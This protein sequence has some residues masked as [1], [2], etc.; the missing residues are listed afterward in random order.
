LTA[1]WNLLPPAALAAPVATPGDNAGL[2]TVTPPSL[3]NG[4]QV[5]S[6]KI[7]ATDASGTPISP[8]KSCIVNAP[9]TNCVITGLTNGETYK[10]IATAT[11]AAGS[12]T[13]SPSNSIVPASRPGVP[14]AVT[15]TRGDEIATVAFTPPAD[16]GG[17][18][19]TT[20]TLTVV[21]TGQTFTGTGSP[22]TVTG[23]TNGSSY[24]FKVSATNAVGVSDSSTAS[25]PV[26]IAGVADAPTVVTAVAGDKSAT[27]SASGNWNTLSGSGGESVTAIIFTSMDGL[28]NCTATLPATSCTV[29]GLTNGTAYTFTA[30]AQ[31]A[32]GNSQSASSNSVTPAGLPTAP[33]IV[34]A[35]S[36][37]KSATITFSGAGANGAAISGYIVKVSPTGETF[38]ATSSPVVIN[39]LTNGGSYS[40]TVAAENTIGQSAFSTA[41]ASATPA[42]APA[43]PTSL[44]VLAGDTSTV[45]SCHL[46]QMMVEIR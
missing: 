39:G 11:N 23:L 31:N 44:A 32:V 7:V 45:V 1:V 19:I 6:Y 28:H 40:F 43:A 8:E 15:A 33:T 16:N 34:T 4:G 37:D 9:A 13:S 20:Y 10:F 5:T 14:T 3:A 46:H 38:T 35:V 18:V 30:V 2:V 27:V 42:S 21:E 41:S 22:I 29:S 25:A 17:S 12:T 26:K 24:T 36:G